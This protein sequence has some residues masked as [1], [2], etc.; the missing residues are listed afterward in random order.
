MKQEFKEE[1]RVND[2][3][4]IDF[5]DMLVDLLTLNPIELEFIRF[6]ESKQ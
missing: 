3:K 2:A 6:L 5:S 1:Q 4:D